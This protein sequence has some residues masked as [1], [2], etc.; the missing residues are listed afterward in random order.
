MFGAAGARP[1]IHFIGGLSRPLPGVCVTGEMS[2][3]RM[4]QHL[5]AKETS[6][7]SSFAFQ[8]LF[9]FDSVAGQG[10]WQQ[11]R[12]CAPGSMPTSLRQLLRRLRLQASI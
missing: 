12:V 5:Y 11:H 7:F 2:S 9:R 1:S 3:R 4:S 8:S 10:L 6:D